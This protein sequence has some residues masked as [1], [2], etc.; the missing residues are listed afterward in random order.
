MALAM[1]NFHG[2]LHGKVHGNL[3]G[4]LHGKPRQAQTAYHGKPRYNGKTQVMEVAM[5]YAVAVAVVFPWLP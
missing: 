4:N 3:H 5:E 2:N 1:Q